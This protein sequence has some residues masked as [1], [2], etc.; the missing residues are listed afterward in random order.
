MNRRRCNTINAARKKRCT[1]TGFTL[2]ELIFVIAI[3]V[4]LAAVFVPLAMDKLSQA[5]QAK[6]DVDINTIANSLAGFFSDM[7]RFPV[8]NGADCNPI[9]GTVDNLKILVFKADSTDVLTTDIPAN[10]P[11]GCTVNW[12]AA[13]NL[14]GGGSDPGRNNAFNHLVV[15]DPNAD[16][17]V[18]A[19]ATDY[20]GWKG[21]YIAKVGKDPWGNHYIAHVGAMQKNGTRVAANTNGWILS[22]GE[23]GIFQTCPESTSLQGDDRGFIFITQ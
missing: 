23:D 19:A 5:N 20:S 15:N 10:A 7:K 11:P 3:I 4:V 17:T 12:N 16:G 9:D 14:E 18:G 6:A 1:Q 13:G 2:I 21:P 22:A 8:C